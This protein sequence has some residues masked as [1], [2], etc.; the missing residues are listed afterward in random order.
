MN[1]HHHLSSEAIFEPISEGRSVP[2]LEGCPV[3]EAEAARVS[4]FLLELRG[5]DAEFVSTS[6]WDDLLLRKRIREAL[7]RESPHVRSLFDRFSI[8]RPAFVSAL[9]AVVALAVWTPSS[10]PRRANHLASINPVAQVIL[11]AWSPLPEESEDEGLAVLAEWTPNEDELVIARCR[12]ACL[13]GLSS[14]EEEDLF[15]DT[16]QNVPRPPITGASPL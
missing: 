11:P 6:E 15:S 1:T 14:R 7:A 3:C 2:G 16:A 5:A 12:A 13:A 8:F 4:A 10:S 9:L